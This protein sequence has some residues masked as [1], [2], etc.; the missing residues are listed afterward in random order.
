MSRLRAPPL[1]VLASSPS[2]AAGRR[3]AN[4]PRASV[5]ARA[6]G[7][8]FVPGLAASGTGNRMTVAPETGTPAELTTLPCAST[9]ADEYSGTDDQDCRIC[10]M[11]LGVADPAPE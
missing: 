1:L 5:V 6:N 11:A 10:A 2:L 7:V 3:S 4:P 9:G 8:S